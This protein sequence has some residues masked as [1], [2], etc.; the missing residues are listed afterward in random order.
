MVRKPCNDCEEK[1]PDE[2]LMRLRRGD[3]SHE[4]VPHGCLTTG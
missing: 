3:G 4:E 1:A 2:E